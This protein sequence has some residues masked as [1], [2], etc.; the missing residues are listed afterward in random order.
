MGVRRRRGVRRLVVA[1]TLR[2]LLLGHALG[3]PVIV[4]Q[5][6]VQR[7]LRVTCAECDF[8]SDGIDIT[9][10][11]R[12]VSARWDPRAQYWATRAGQAWLNGERAA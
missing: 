2:C 3:A 12:P 5:T 4:E 7:R 1:M 6:T 8:V 9:P 10:T 11:K